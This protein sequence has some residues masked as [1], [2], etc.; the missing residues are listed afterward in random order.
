MADYDR[1]WVVQTDLA[2][3]AVLPENI[4]YPDRSIT[5]TNFGFSAQLFY[6]KCFF[7]CSLPCVH[8]MRNNV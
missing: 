5:K 1:Q 8:S 6:F 2:S 3:K 7:D 4:E